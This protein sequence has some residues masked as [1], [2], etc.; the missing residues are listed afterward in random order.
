[1]SKPSDFSNN[2]APKPDKVGRIGSVFYFFYQI[3]TELTGGE[4][5]YIGMEFSLQP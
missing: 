3:P 5:A 2:N 4:G 1:M